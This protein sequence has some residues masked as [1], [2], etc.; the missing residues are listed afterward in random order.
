MPPPKVGQRAARGGEKFAVLNYFE[1][2]KATSGVLTDTVGRYMWRGAF[3]EFKCSA[4]G[5]FRSRPQAEKE[6][7]ELLDQVKIYPEK[8]PW[9]NAGPNEEEM[10][11][12]T[13][14]PPTQPAPKSLQ[15]L[16]PIAQ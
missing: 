15:R 13:S 2:T 5:G 1:E 3:V 7:L 14:L 8:Y 9:D 16:S 6:W 4:D 10:I 12:V 11:L